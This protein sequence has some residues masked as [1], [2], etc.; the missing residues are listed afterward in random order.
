MWRPR[1]HAGNIVCWYCF[2]NE[3]TQWYS[4]SQWS[5]KLTGR[6]IAKIEIKPV[7]AQ[8][9][10]NP[11]S[12]RKGHL[13]TKVVL[14]TSQWPLSSILHP[15][16]CCNIRKSDGCRRKLYQLKKI[17][18]F[19]K[20][21]VSH[22]KMEMKATKIIKYLGLGWSDSGSCFYYTHLFCSM[23]CNQKEDSSACVLCVHDKSCRV[24][25]VDI[26]HW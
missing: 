12:Y 23:K 13:C 15:R 17:K 9:K 6:D 1:C 22:M 5:F 24:N 4:T 8:S 18:K 10:E 26:L 21:L 2:S 3:L 14:R 25:L 19:C 16:Q 20:L 7:I 11:P